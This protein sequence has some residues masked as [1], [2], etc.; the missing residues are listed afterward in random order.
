M[1]QVGKNEVYT[2]ISRGKRVPEYLAQ[3]FKEHDISIETMP[4]DTFR[5]SVIGYY[6][7]TFWL[8]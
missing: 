4:V 8:S 5:K 7:E 3:A 6:I 2:V 1:K